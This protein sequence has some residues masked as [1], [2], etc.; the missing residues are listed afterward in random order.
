M[1]IYGM[2]KNFTFETDTLSP[3]SPYY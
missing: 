1:Q 2:L 3:H